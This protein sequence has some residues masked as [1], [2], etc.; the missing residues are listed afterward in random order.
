MIST[1]ELVEIS[2]KPS[3]NGSPYLAKLI[4]P[5]SKIL[6]WAKSISVKS[7]RCHKLIIKKLAIVFAAILSYYVKEGIRNLGID[8]YLGCL[9]YRKMRIGNEWNYHTLGFAIALDPKK[10]KLSE[11]SRSVRCTPRKYEPMIDIPY[12]KVLL[13]LGVEKNYDWMYF[14]IKS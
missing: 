11:S 7:N 14:E 1:A 6:A 2:G 12:R 5:Y 3:E 8:L 9:H 13:S 10:N 4:L